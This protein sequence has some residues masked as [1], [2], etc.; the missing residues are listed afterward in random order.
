VSVEVL[1]DLA[2]LRA[3]VP[4]WEALAAEAAEPNPFYEHWMLLPALEAY[5]KEAGFRC[6]VVWD[7][8]VLGALFPMTLERR[9]R[10][11]PVAA[12]RSWRHRNMLLSTPLVRRKGGAPHAGCIRAFLESGVAP[13]VEFEHLPAGGPVYGALAEEASR[14]GSPWFASDAYARA[15]LDRDRD[16][17]AG[18][19]SNLKNNLR[20]CEKRLGALGR[21]E[22]V[23]LAPDGDVAGWIAGFLRL[24]AAGW[25]GRAG[26]A[27]ACREDDR[28]FASETFAEAHRRGRLL[29]TGLDLD[30]KP[31]ARHLLFTAGEGAYTFKI[32]YDEAY[33]RYSPGILAEVDNV[34]QFIELGDARPGL[35]WIDSFTAPENVTTGRVW[36]D[37][38]TVQ[39]VAIG[40]RGAGRLAVAAMPL[41]RLAKTCLKDWRAG[42]KERGAAGSRAPGTSSGD[43]TPDCTVFGPRGGAPQEADNKVLAKPPNRHVELPLHG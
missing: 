34:R 38:L 35:R 23:R 32:A 6:V 9:Y 36:K 41:M 5:G 31:I 20:R 8:G 28:R 43:R 11:L 26:S 7:N 16:P 12:L 39:R 17:R 4:E 13:V 27:L 14:A 30:G 33:A 42:R 2:A 29:V 40:T 24:E 1:S 37:R 15:L 19:N 3:L 18:F 22:P 21:L 25:K 10:G